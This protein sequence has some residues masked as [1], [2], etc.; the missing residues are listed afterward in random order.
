MTREFAK[1]VRRRTPTFPA[2]WANYYDC[3]PWGSGF[4]RCTSAPGAT[5]LTSG[6]C[7]NIQTGEVYHDGR[8]SD[9]LPNGSGSLQTP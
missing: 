3:T 5:V 8:F 7:L 4:F 1:I 2:R 9:E 6:R